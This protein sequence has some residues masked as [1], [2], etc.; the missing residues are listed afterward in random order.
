[1]HKGTLTLLSLQLGTQARLGCGL[2]L[3][4]GECE[5]GK[6]V[7][8]LGV[9]ARAGDGGSIS[10]I[11]S[12]LCSSPRSREALINSSRR[13]IPDIALRAG[14]WV[15]SFRF[16]RPSQPRYLDLLGLGRSSPL[17]LNRDRSEAGRGPF[18]L[19][20]L[21]GYC[22]AGHQHLVGL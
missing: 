16:M 4:D 11:Q 8:R 9:K 19:A 15:S 5:P 12:R 2:H 13:H 20:G 10:F 17:G 3:T 7:L 1:M 18:H 21:T 14:C 6:N 22:G